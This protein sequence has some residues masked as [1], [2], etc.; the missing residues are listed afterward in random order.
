MFKSY[1]H[2]ERINT[3]EVE[4]ILDGVVYVFPKIDGTAGV[5]WQEDGEIKC[6]SRNRQLSKDSDN[7]G[8]YTKFHDDER[9]KKVFEVHPEWRIFGEMMK[10]H[11]LK[12]YRD[13][14]WGR[15][16]IYDI[17]NGQK[18]I[19]YDIYNEFLTSLGL[20]V[21]PP[22]KI[23]NNPKEDYLYTL[24]DNNQ[25]LIKD[26]LGNGE[27][28]VIKNYDYVNKFGRQCW[29]KIVRTEFKEANQRAFKQ[30]IINGGNVL[31]EEIAEKYITTTLVDKVY[32]NIVNA[33]GG[34]SS[35]NIPELLN[36]TW[37]DFIREETYDILKK[38]N[39]PTINFKLLNKKVFNQ[40]KKVK[41]EVF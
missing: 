18:Y 15:F 4:D 17:H 22:M 27:G 14:V 23:I 39:N 3:I 33:L 36:R 34:F 40:V 10:P 16:F 6:G 5:I 24:L 38:Y 41:P 25:Y 32:A 30:N 35:K 28:I 31:E 20:D 21:I 29:A 2:V 12:T 37:Y 9:I 26:G 11:T 13:E 19:H 8:F 1:M 7:A